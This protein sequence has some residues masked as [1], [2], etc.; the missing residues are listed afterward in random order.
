[1]IKRYLIE[2]DIILRDFLGTT[3]LSSHLI[4]KITNG[5]GRFI[6][7]DQNVNKSYLLKKGDT[8][9]IVLPA[10]DQGENILS[11]KKDFDIVYED[12]YLLVINKEPNVSCIPTIKHFNN[13]LANY[14]M[15]YYKINGILSNIHFVNR[16]DAMTSGLVILAKNSYINELMKNQKIIKK[17]V[18]EVEGILE[19]EGIIETGIRRIGDETIK[20]EVTYDFINSKTEYKV[21]GKNVFKNN[22]TFIEATLHT[23]KTHQLRLHFEHLGH[24]IIGDSLYGNKNEEG[25]LHLHSYY[26]EFNHP[27]TNEL[28]RLATYPGWFLV[29]LESD[30]LNHNQ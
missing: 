30:Q 17:Y 21:L 16:L 9:E 24:P 27:V 8:L 4:T 19:T 1:M 10:S 15:S 22:S 29:M 14:V 28:I 11:I 20:R 2:E 6:V 25:I 18:I 5:N 3:D 13:S 23:G 26:L 7:N 12:A